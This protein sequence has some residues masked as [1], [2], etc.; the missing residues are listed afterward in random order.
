MH[1]N[2]QIRGGH[3]SCLSFCVL[4][5]VMIESISD[6]SIFL[7]ENKGLSKMEGFAGKCLLRRKKDLLF[8]ASLE[9]CRNITLTK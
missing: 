6:K 3:V 5:N 4:Q 1:L 9:Q 8:L 7:S 2:V